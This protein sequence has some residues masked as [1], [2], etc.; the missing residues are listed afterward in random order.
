VAATF[1]FDVG[2]PY[3]YLAAE[4][5]DSALPGPVAWQP[6][7]LGG[8]FKLNG[9]S[10]WAVGDAARRRAGIADVERRAREYGLPAP[11]WPQGWPRDYLLAMRA[12]TFA[13]S[14]GR[15][16]DFARQALRDAFQRGCELSDP[17]QVMRAAEQVGL[18][19]REVHDA[20]RD[21][22]VKRALRQ[23]T[24]DAHRLGVFGVPSVAVG[25]Q[26]LWGDDRLQ[27]AA[28]LG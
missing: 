10:S 24:E 11:V 13:S 1:Y 6:I 2:S 5:L 28:A 27:E 26:I 9:R 16:P 8:L 25:G 15:G 17:E 3:A 23:A 19:R 22:Q 12:A 20:V 21:P 14:V 7:L 4:R 18:D